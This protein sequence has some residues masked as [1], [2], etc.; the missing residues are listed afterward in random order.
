MTE[1]EI[2]RLFR[3]KNYIDEDEALLDV[4]TVRFSRVKAIQAED[5]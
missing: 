5:D 4:E 1:G 3:P 2:R